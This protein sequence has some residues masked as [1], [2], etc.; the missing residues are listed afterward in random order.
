MIRVVLVLIG[1][2]LS[3]YGIYRITGGREMV[4]ERVA[5]RVGKDTGMVGAKF[6][7]I[8]SDSWREVTVRAG[9]SG[10]SGTLEG[11]LEIDRGEPVVFVEILWEDE[12]GEGEHRFAK[13][14]V[15]GDG[16]KTFTHVF[17]A[18]GDIDDFVELPF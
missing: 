9:G 10:S 2:G 8:L 12:A 3:G 4:V 7:L 11:R 16:E 18:R 1:I 13:L 15:E 14:V 17:D 6:R 5:A